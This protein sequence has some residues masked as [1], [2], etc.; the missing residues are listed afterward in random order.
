MC[1]QSPVLWSDGPVCVCQ[2][3]RA[4]WNGTIFFA[5]LMFAAFGLSAE[6]WRYYIF[7]LYD[8]HK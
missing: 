5:F 2:D 3:I 8:A 1:K 7:Y 6:L 4:V